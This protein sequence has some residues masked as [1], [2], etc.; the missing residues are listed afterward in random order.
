MHK[1]HQVS[2][3]DKTPVSLASLACISPVGGIESSVGIVAILVA[4]GAYSLA[5]PLVPIA[6][7]LG[8]ALLLVCGA[9]IT[10]KLARPLVSLALGWGVYRS[11]CRLGGKPLADQV[12]RHYS[13]GGSLDT[14]QLTM[15][16]QQNQG[17]SNVTGEGRNQ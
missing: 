15:L 5:E 1:P 8:T 17:R 2:T 14:A 7:S 11:L 12:A 4:G 10:E 13:A 6:G 9:I 16:L 3:F